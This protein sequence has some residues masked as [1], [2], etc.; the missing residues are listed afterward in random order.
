MISF[1]SYLL[2]ESPFDDAKKKWK[3]DGNNESYIDNYITVF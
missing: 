1:L 2:L 3:L